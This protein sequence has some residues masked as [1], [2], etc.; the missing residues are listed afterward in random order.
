MMLVAG[1]WCSW[2]PINALI[3]KFAPVHAR[4]AWISSYSVLWL[5]YSKLILKSDNEPAIVKVLQEPLRE[6]KVTARRL[7]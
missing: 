7:K 1:S 4:I 3:F 6:L 5:G 2:L